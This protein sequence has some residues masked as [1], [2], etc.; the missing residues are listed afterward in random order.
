MGCEVHGGST[1]VSHAG[2]N[3]LSTYLQGLG[4]VLHRGQ[5]LVQS[6]EHLAQLQVHGQHVLLTNRALEL[7]LGI[8][9]QPQ[10]VVALAQASL[11]PPVLVVGLQGARCVQGSAGSGLAEPRRALHRERFGAGVAEEG[12]WGLRG[13]YG[14]VENDQWSRAGWK[15]MVR[16][17]WKCMV[18][19]ACVAAAQ[20]SRAFR[21]L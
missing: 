3:E 7:S 21:G 6:H 18:R 4:V 8:A 13:W 11:P 19:T 9:V 2:R 20:S 15:C 5:R 1:P 14:S 10:L 16:G 17:G 12:K